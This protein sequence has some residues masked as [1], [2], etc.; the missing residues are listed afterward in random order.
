MKKIVIT[1]V[2]LVAISGV[3]AQKYITK[4]GHIKFYS[5]TKVEDI[6]ANN[7]SVNAALDIKTGEMVVKVLMKSFDFEK[8]LMQQHFNENYVESHIY[9]NATFEGKVINISSV[10]L[11]NKGKHEVEIEG[12]LTIHDVTK[13]IKEKAI[14]TV[15]DNGIKGFAVF[16]VKVADYEIKIP[17]MVTSKIAEEI[18]VTVDLLL[19]EYKK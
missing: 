4:T 8:A 3:Y 18:E 6:E 13:P 1:I 15:T 5:H 12:N 11:T 19:K 7:K 16:N 17:K 9:P 2:L 10:D 14:L